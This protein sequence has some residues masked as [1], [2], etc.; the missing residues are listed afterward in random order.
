MHLLSNLFLLYRLPGSPNQSGQEKVQS[1]HLQAMI[2][3]WQ[4]FF[5][6][7]L[8][9][10]S[11]LFA[12]FSIITIPPTTSPSPFH[13]IAPYRWREPNCNCCNITNENGNA[14]ALF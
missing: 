1:P 10:T 4:E 3:E 5:L 9:T 7:L 6:L 11:A 14:I 2:F 13:V 12:P 8:L